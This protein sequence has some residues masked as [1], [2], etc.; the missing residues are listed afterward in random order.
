MYFE[1]IFVRDARKCPVCNW[2]HNLYLYT[3]LFCHSNW[4]SVLHAYCTQPNNGGYSDLKRPI[5]TY[6]FLLT[7]LHRMLVFLDLP[8][9]ILG[10]F[11]MA[12][13]LLLFTFNN[14]NLFIR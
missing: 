12:K 5:Y 3:V 8:K 4:Y 13:Y 14:F 6:N 11:I 2:I 1:L 10:P 7:I 9:A